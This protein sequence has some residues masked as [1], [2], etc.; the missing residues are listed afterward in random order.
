MKHHK[1]DR[2]SAYEIASDSVRSR[3]HRIRKLKSQLRDH[4]RRLHYEPLLTD[5]WLEMSDSINQVAEIAF[6]EMSM[7]F[8]RAF[9]TSENVGTRV[10]GRK[11][12][13]TLWDQDDDQVAIQ[14]LLEEGKINLCIN[15]MFEYFRDMSSK[16]NAAKLIHG[17]MVK[18]GCTEASIE[19]CVL[20][21]EKGTG[22]LIRLAMEHVEVLQILDIGTL[23][24]HFSNVMTNAV[25]RVHLWEKETTAYFEVD[26][27]GVDKLQEFVVFHYLADLMK[28]LDD[29]DE[30][31]IM[32][33]FEEQ[34]L[35]AKAVD[36]VN[37]LKH[38]CRYDILSSFFKFL[39]FCFDCET[40][41]AENDRFIS[42]DTKKRCIQLSDEFL[43]ETMENSELGKKDFKSLLAEIDRWKRE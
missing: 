33:I 12:G 40:Y 18:T 27:L 6:L 38:S 15:L 22:I 16:E 17:A 4:I 29:L 28:H 7:P 37:F 10:I 34:K 9:G 1:L 25:S 14:I 26:Y 36:H 24:V 19:K 20:L 23:I 35:I 21:F 11:E 30:E 2:V 31:R 8:N 42:S 39:N 41:L 13:G 3:E 43:D 32:N 5:S